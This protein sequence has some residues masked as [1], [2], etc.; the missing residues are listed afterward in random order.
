VP[1]STASISDLNMPFDHFKPKVVV[2]AHVLWL[3]K[4]RRNTI[5][6]AQLPHRAR[7][8]FFF[9]LLQVILI[10]P[11]SPF[12]PISRRPFAAVCPGGIEG[13]P[14]TVDRMSS[15]DA[16]VLFSRTTHHFRHSRPSVPLPCTK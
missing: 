5:E 14:T 6:R 7:F 8:V 16:S 12:S 3:G 9:L 1:C 11:L 13:T 2:V 4:T 10:P 15:R